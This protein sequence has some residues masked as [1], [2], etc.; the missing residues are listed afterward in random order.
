MTT[1]FANN[2]IRLRG[3]KNLTQQELGDASG[4]SPSQISRYEAGQAS[5][6]KTVL[7][8]LADALGVSVDELLGQPP[9]TK[10]VTIVLEEPGGESM[11]LTIDRSAF[12]LLQKA[13]EKTGK[14]LGD[15]V[16][17][18]LLW[19]LQMIKS[20]PEFAEGLKRHIEENR[21]AKNGKTPP[22]SP[23]DS[24]IKVEECE[25]CEATKLSD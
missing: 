1:E 23:S 4:V 3:S 20:S 2:L 14:P 10:T 19:G 7:G 21:K 25:S 13:A 11:P 6:R 17:D 8:K 12:E 24:D 18:T 9:E 15:I 22:T 5:P 16:S